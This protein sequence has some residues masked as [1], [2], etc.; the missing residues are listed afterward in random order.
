MS[1]VPKIVSRMLDTHVDSLIARNASSMQLFVEPAGVAKL[2]FD[3][4]D[5]SEMI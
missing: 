2:L 3:S 5:V 1:S 4:L